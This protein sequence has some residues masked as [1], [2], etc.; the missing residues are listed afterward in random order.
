M[1]KL[2]SIAVLLFATAAGAQ[3]TSPKTLQVV[4]RAGGGEDPDT[5][6]AGINSISVSPN[7]DVMVWD[8]KSFVFRLF[9]DNGKFIRKVGR[10]GAGPGEYNHVNGSSFGPDGRFYVWDG[11]NARLNVYK[12]DG[13]FEKQVMHPVR[14]LQTNDALS[15]DNQGRAWFRIFMLDKASGVHKG[16]WVRMRTADGST[17]DTVMAPELTG[18]DPK[19][20]A[21]GNGGTANYDMPYGRYPSFALTS[22]GE[23]MIAQAGKYEIDVP[24]RGKTVKITRA[25]SPVP[26]LPDE[27]ERSKEQYEKNL[28]QTQPDWQWPASIATTKP[29]IGSI[30]SALDGRVWV[31]LYTET[32][33]YKPDESVKLPPG[34]PTVFFRDGTNK[35]DIFEP[36][37]RYIGT[38]STP[39][40][41]SIMAMR[42][43]FVWGVAL[44]DD[45]VPTLVKMKVVPPFK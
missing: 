34:S 2:S 17:I 13:D 42:G 41:T 38:I 18:G 12:S 19:L 28:R 35:W 5:S 33:R 29:P 27:R 26:V 23:I 16:A 21:R 45:D 39:R 44:D 3:T 11:A 14:G 32:E 9:N 8:R 7:G 10:K 4:W 37:G 30:T 25:F 36:D 1:R 43:D 6:V 15:I 20:I 22:A 40:T 24:Y 31:K